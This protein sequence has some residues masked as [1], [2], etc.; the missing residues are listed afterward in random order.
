M[1]SF[2]RLDDEL[3]VP[4]GLVSPDVLCVYLPGT[5]MLE[6]RVSW[7]G[8]EVKQPARGVMLAGFIKREAFLEDTVLMPRHDAVIPRL[9][10]TTTLVIFQLSAARSPEPI[11]PSRE[12][13]MEPSRLS[14]HHTRDGL[15]ITMDPRP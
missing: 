1:I 8:L 13:R 7:T 3:S 14:H 15:E 12:A 5:P 11:D 2:R 6:R 9:N 4:R 10:D